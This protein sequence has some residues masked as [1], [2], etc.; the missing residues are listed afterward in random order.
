MKKILI[1]IFSL[2]LLTGCT[3]KKNNDEFIKVNQNENV[4]KEQT[5]ADLK[6]NDITL[7]YD[8]GVSNFRAKINN[9]TEN[10]INISEIKIIFKN[11]NETIITSLIVNDINEIPLQSYKYIT[12]TSDI[13][14][15]DA[16]SIEYEIK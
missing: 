1:I 8:K 15:S 9:E 14:L 6:I 10:N 4:I 13:D 11:K 16:Y 3:S 2:L 12:M 5:I 7:Y